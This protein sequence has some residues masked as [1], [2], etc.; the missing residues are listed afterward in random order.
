MKKIVFLEQIDTFETSELK[1]TLSSRYEIV[2]AENADKAIS[3]L[4]ELTNDIALVLIYKPSMMDRINVLI[5]YME[6][7]NTIIFAVPAII[8]TSKETTEKDM[9]YLKDPVIDVISLYTPEKILFNRLERSIQIIN[10][11]SFQEFADMLRVLPSLIYLKDGRGKYVF[12][13]QYWHHLD[14][15]DDP[16]WTIQGKTDME[17]RKDIE[18]AKRAYESDL[19]VIKDGKCKSYIIEENEDGQHEYLQIIKEPLKYADGRIRGIIALINNVT[20]QEEMK[21]K[22]EKLSYTDELTG[23]HN[24]AFFEEYIALISEESYPMGIISADCDNL[25]FINDNYGHMVGD[26]YIRMAVTFMKSIIP[27]S[28]VICRTGGDEFIIFLPGVGRDS[29]ERYVNILNSMD[30]VFQVMGR[31]VEVSFG[32][33]VI[34]DPGENVREHIIESDE[35]MYKCKNGKKRIKEKT[36]E[37]RR[38]QEEENNSEGEKP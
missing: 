27:E 35:E 6:Q 26:E 25:K 29:V 30:N 23:V 7:Y 20:E 14:H 31:N 2:T 9:D 8:I 24:R 10:S 18:N 37:L 1:N 19:Q 15:Y 17:I 5:E 33:S 36:E 16:D 32:F 22:L 11:A 13:S 4:D 34:E 21:R 28:S 3:L 38:K 12:C